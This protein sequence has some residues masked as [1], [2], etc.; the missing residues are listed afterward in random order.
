MLEKISRGARSLTGKFILCAIALLA[1]IFLIEIVAISTKSGSV[2]SALAL[3]HSR[4]VGEHYASNTENQL[5]RRMASVEAISRSF[6]M[7]RRSWVTD[8]SAYNGIMRSMIEDDKDIFS[9]W[10]VFEP[11]AIDT[12]ADHPDDVGSNSE[13]RFTPIWYRED[14][15]LKVDAITDLSDKG[16]AAEFYRRVAQT[17]KSLIT[18][19]YRFK[20]GQ[21]TVVMVSLVA[22]IIV[23][24][25]F[26]G[27]IGISVPLQQFAD[28]LGKVRPLDS[29]TVSLITNQGNWAA[30]AD[31]AALGNPITASNAQL[32]SIL[33]SLKSG[34]FLDFTDK[35]LEN[36]QDNQNYLIPITIGATKS[37]W[38]LL[39]TIP[40]AKV[41][42]P[43]AAI[44]NLVIGAKLLALIILTLTLAIAGVVIVRRPL[45][46][47][48]AVIDRLAQGDYDVEIG[49]TGRKDEIGQVNR[50]LQIFQK[51]LLLVNRMEQERRQAE[52]QAAA[53]RHAEME[54]LA[55]AF[56][57]A[58]SGIASAVSD[59]ADQLQSN[60]SS[61][62]SIAETTST[63][64]QTVASASTQAT[65]N[66]QSVASAVEELVASVEEISRQ[67][68]QS[69]DV[70]RD[71]VDRVAHTNTTMVSLEEAAQRIGD[72]TGF[73]QQIANL[74][75]L[76][77]LNAT[78]EAA[79]AGE[80]GKGFAVVAGEV[81]TLAHQTAQ[82][83]DDI[84]NQIQQMQSTTG[85]VASAI[86]EVGGMISSINES[87]NSVASA[88]VQQGA[89]TSEI[90]RNL[91]MAADKTRDVSGN[92][93]EVTRASGEAG[94]MAQD[95]LRASRDLSGQADTLEVEVRNFIQRI[96]TA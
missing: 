77:A 96:R 81:K 84:R 64:A 6:G 50:A 59:G 16:A 22:P 12:D 10:T 91:Q 24:R 42:E 57:A 88:A 80:A 94:D 34:Q 1:A 68:Q 52:E 41:F 33:D 38:G 75:N 74:T 61:L 65:G 31:S 46:Q 92:I 47:T 73:I 17:R 66:V 5:N 54:Q 14:G 36:G 51:N 39:V 15:Q 82:A 78:I 89:A 48:I 30:V 53:A 37:P 28:E 43:A 72:V 13:G 93:T 3:K 7:M 69:A 2:I 87:I 40:Q 21:R 8:R 19:P 27:A 49:A 9:L 71:A 35:S 67:I 79:R 60:A 11:G 44:R 32:S 85:E 26:I 55:D 23:D 95:V 76:L 45:A 25:R 70:A 29:G 20:V 56:E 83:T 90:S 18:E 63:Q 86:R 4:E 58:L 62:T